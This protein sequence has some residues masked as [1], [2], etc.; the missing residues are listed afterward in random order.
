M[1]D[2]DADF[3]GGDDEGY[4]GAGGH[5]P[6]FAVEFDVVGFQGGG[7]GGDVVGLEAEVVE[8]V[9]GFGG[10][11][12]RVFAFG[13][14]GDGH[15]V[16][17][18]E[19]EFDRFGVGQ[20][21]LGGDFGAE[22]VAVEF[23][24]IVR[25]GAAEVEVVVKDVHGFSSW[26]G[27]LGLVYHRKGGGGIRRQEWGEFLLAA[28]RLGVGDV[29]RRYLRGGGSPPGGPYQRGVTRSTVLVTSPVGG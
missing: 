4:G 29:R 21:P 19:G 17:S 9:A 13:A 7:Q 2:F 1:D 8:A 14:A 11:G 3:V 12:N 22:V 15:Q 24:G 25:V 18:V 10:A 23:G 16:G 28:V 6:G 5:Y 27:R 20:R 26:G